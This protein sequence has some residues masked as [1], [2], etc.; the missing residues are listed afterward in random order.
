MVRRSL[1]FKKY[2]YTKNVIFTMMGKIG[3]LGTLVFLG[4]IL[5]IFF[6]VSYNALSAEYQTGTTTMDVTVRGYV[7]ISVSTNITAGITFSTQDPNTDDNNASNNNF[8]NP[9]TGYNLTVDSSSTVNINFTHAS[10]RS[11]LT[12]GTYTIDIGNV[13]YNSNS[14]ARDGSNLYDA[15]TSEA[16]STSWIGM[17]TCGDLGDNGN[18]WA[19]YFLDVPDQQEPGAYEAGYCWCGRQTT[20]DIS[21]C[22][23]CT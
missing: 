7:S 3:L 16:M 9:G 14:T 20:A 11:N 21:V 18:C 8:W 17:E 4:T 23:S 6:G 22:G 1:V 2:L 5:V 10:N 12:T 13:T 19:T 15:G